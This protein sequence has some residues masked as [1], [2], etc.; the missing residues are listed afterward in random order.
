MS[1]AL[2]AGFA[3]YLYYEYKV[4]KFEGFSVEIKSSLWLIVFMPFISLFDY[5][6]SDKLG[7]IGL[8]NAYSP[9]HLICFLAGISII[10]YLMLKYSRRT[11]ALE[12]VILSQN[13]E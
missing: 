8:F 13:K 2:L 5:L 4:K 1:V 3:I 6:A 9:A 11:E 10:F 7:G 12:K